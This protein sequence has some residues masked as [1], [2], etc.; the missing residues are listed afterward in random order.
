M[1]TTDKNRFKELLAELA[2]ITDEVFVVRKLKGRVDELIDIAHKDEE[3]RATYV[4]LLSELLE[5]GYPGPWEV[6][7]YAMYRLRWPEILAR[8]RELLR[9]VDD[10]GGPPSSYGRYLETVIEA[11]DDAWQDADLWECGSA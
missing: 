7:P 10:K 5:K 3:H 6:L 11:F 8:C 1:N 9:A 2:M 4:E